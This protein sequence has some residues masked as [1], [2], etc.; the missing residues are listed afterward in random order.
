MSSYIHICATSVSITNYK[1]PGNRRRPETSAQRSRPVARATDLPSESSPFVLD[2]VLVEARTE[3][4]DLGTSTGAAD[5]KHTLTVAFLPIASSSDGPKRRNRCPRFTGD[6]EPRLWLVF[7]NGEG[8]VE[9][10]ANI[11]TRGLARAQFAAGISTDAAHP[12]YGLHSLRHAAASLFIEQN[13]SPKRVQQLMGH[14]TIQMT[15]DVYG[16]LFP[17]AD[18]D[19]VAFGQLQARLLVA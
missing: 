2:I 13:F 15:F 4:Q 8:N 3:R 7:P 19:Q 11:H 6:G 16:H 9:R 5:I 1:N 12:K 17:S 18:D 10:H 14:S